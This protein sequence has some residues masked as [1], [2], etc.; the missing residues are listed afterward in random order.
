M[1]ASMSPPPPPPLSEKAATGCVLATAVPPATSRQPLVG[2]KH[3]CL[4]FDIKVGFS[5]QLATTNN[6][7]APDSSL[8]FC[9]RLST[10]YTKA[11]HKH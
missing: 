9:L 11:E 3:F 8:K 4:R 10:V 7:P 2:R 1:V 5:E 6:Q